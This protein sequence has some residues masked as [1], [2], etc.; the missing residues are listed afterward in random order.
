MG[1]AKGAARPAIRIRNCFAPRS[2]LRE[3]LRRTVPALVIAVWFCKGMCVA[4]STAK[5]PR[6]V[7][8]QVTLGRVLSW[9]PADTE[10][11]IGASGPFPF[12][13][14]AAIPAPS[15]GELSPAELALR[16]QF[17][18]P[19]SLFQLNNGGLR[20]SLKDKRVALAIEGSRHFRPP[21]VGGAMRYEG[22][23]IVLMESGAQVDGDAFMKSAASSAR[24]FEKIAGLSVAAFEE[25]KENGVWTTFVAFPRKDVVAVAS[26][27]AYLRTVLTRL[28][29][30]PG[31]RALPDSLPEWKYLNTRAPVWGIRHYDKSQARLDPT[32]PFR[33]TDPRA[34]GV[35]FYF[36]PFERKQVLITYLSATEDYRSVLLDHLSMADADA[37]PR[38]EFQIHFRQPG[39]GALQGSV[40]LSPAE[41]LYRLLFG[42]AAMLGHSASV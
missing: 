16:T 28:N 24:R 29:G 34:V 13:D 20:E 17:N 11:V 42:L 8:R 38:G 30:T 4:Q 6:P 21:P 35:T 3:F 41:A 33:D 36:E 31:P 22:C 19:L 23:A 1:S 39:P 37:A 2:V 14:L 7:P 25:L 10:V 32:S 12:P 18:F 9:L 27:L 15:S 5:Q 40:S 26:D